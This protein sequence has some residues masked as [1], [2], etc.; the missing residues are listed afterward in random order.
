VLYRSNHL[1]RLFEMEFRKHN[2][3]AKLIGGQEFFQRKEVKD[4]VAYLKLILNDRDGQSLL[5]VI[6][7]PPRGIGDKAI[8]TLR[9]SQKNTGKPMVSLL[10][11]EAYGEQVSST[12]RKSAAKLGEIIEQ[13]RNQF[14]EPGRLLQKAQSYL[15]ETGYLN[16]LQRI[17]RDVKEADSRRENVLEFLSYLGQWERDNAGAASLSKFLEE[18]SLMDENDRTDDDDDRDAPFLSTVHAAKGLEFPFVFIIGMENRVFPHERAVREG[19]EDEERRLFYVAITRAKK[20]LVITHSCK[21]FKYGAYEYAAPSPFLRSI[22]D[23]LSEHIG[24]EDYFPKMT[25][26]DRKAAF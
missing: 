22:P 19:N 13:Y 12:A 5:R 25:D 24:D 16:G 26:E 20:N 3:R 10:R 6:A 18:Y 11:D 21:R 8:E 9:L 15:E 7:L 2:I 17:Y 14:S 23:N 1:S 4:A